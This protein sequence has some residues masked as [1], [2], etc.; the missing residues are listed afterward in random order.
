MKIIRRRLADGTIREYRYQRYGS[1]IPVASL[2]ALIQDYRAAPEFGRLSAATKRA[3]HRAIGRMEPLYR[4]RVVDIKRRHVM[5]LRDR[6]RA[7]PALANQIVA[8]FSILMEYAVALEW[9]ETNPA[10]RV[11]SLPT[12]SY[13]RWT[14]A[15][16]ALALERFPPR[17][18]RGVLLALYTGQRVSDVVA[19]RWPDYDGEGIHVAQQKTGT[20]LW[21]PCPSPLRAAIEGWKDTLANDGRG[22][23]AAVTMVTTA[24]GTPYGAEAFSKAVSC[25]IAKHP[26]LAGLVFHG[27]RKTAAA[28]LAEAGCSTHEIAAITGHKT[29]AMLQHYTD[30]AEQRTRARAAVIKLENARDTRTS[31]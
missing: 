15:Q 14:D 10:R 13:R 23:V 16:I 24:R 12:G 1:K 30:E 9:R 22:A 26:E 6:H 21:I 4:A 17:L 8:V 19:M 11:G 25:E 3:Y 27:L 2:G 18:A 20:R 5:K 7:T 29:L 28:K 31:R